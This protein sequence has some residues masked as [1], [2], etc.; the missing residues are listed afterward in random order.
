[1]ISLINVILQIIP[2]PYFCYF[3]GSQQAFRIMLMKNK[4]QTIVL[5]V[6]E[7]KTEISEG[8]I[9]PEGSPTDVKHPREDAVSM[10]ELVK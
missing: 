1:M 9:F 10:S 8:Q 4:L 3:V 7:V 2:F 6:S 5:K